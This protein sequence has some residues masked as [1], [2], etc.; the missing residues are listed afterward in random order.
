[1]TDSAP[2][3]NVFV[4]VIVGPAEPPSMADDRAKPDI[5]AAGGPAGSPRVD[6]VFCLWQCDK[7]NHGWREGP[8]LTVLWQSVDLLPGLHP[9]AKSVSN[10]KR[11]LLSVGER[12]PLILDIGRFISTFEE[13]IENAP[14]NFYMRSR[15]LLRRLQEVAHYCSPKV[16]RANR[17]GLRKIRARRG[18]SSGLVFG[19]GRSPALQPGL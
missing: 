10:E 5:A 14:G 11:I 8:P 6:V 17:A 13:V 2:H 19:R 18:I 9:P 3:P 7:N 1:M 16:T 12:E 15:F 4:L